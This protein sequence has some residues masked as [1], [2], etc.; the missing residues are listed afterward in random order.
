[1]KFKSKIYSFLSSNFK[2]KQKTVLLSNNLLFEIK[3]SILKKY[4]FRLGYKRKLLAEKNYD[5]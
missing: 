3:V 1:M 5:D 4:D 2:E